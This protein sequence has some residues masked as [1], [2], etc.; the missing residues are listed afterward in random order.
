MS[1]QLFVAVGA[2]SS[3][4]LRE[5]GAVRAGGLGVGENCTNTW[6]YGTAESAISA[7]GMMHQSVSDVLDGPSTAQSCTSSEGSCTEGIFISAE[8]VRYSRE[9]HK[10]LESVVYESLVTVSQ[11]LGVEVHKRLVSGLGS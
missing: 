5:E 8:E 3:R 10:F 9:L 2:L 4:Y 1:T 7:G 11:C 6:M